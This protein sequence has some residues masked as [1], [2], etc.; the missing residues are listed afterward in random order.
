MTSELRLRLAALQGDAGIGL[1]PRLP[2]PDGLPHRPDRLYGSGLGEIGFAPDPERGLFVR[3]EAV[4]LSDLGLEPHGLALERLSAISEVVPVGSP[5]GMVLCDLETTGLQRGAGTVPFL[6]GWATVVGQRLEL[7]QWLLPQLG[8]EL[9]LVEAALDRL[10]AASLLVTYNGASYDLPLLRART[11]MTGVDR[12]WPAPPHLDLLPLV[13][14]LFR[15]RLPRCTLRSAEVGLLHRTRQGD[16]PGREAPER[17]WHFLRTGEAAPL[18]AV[19][20]HNR[21]DVVSL[22]RLL[23][24]LARHLDLEAPHPSDWLSLGRLA[25]S[26]GRLGEAAESYRRAERLSPPPLDRAGALRRARLLRRQGEADQ[27]RE[28]WTAIWQRWGDPEAAEALCVE[29]EHRQGDPRAALELARR[30]LPDA[31]VGWDQRFARRIWRLEARLG[32]PGPQASAAPD[33]GGARPWA[34]WLPGGPSYEAWLALRR[35]S[36]VGRERRLSSVG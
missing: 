30:A 13:R 15:H 8:S 20:Q 32:T 12:A 34:A 23:D 24:R 31:P 7:E 25:E 9:P 22:V 2:D 35:R 17:Y 3:S 19:V 18:E 28:A 6:Y 27:A 33:P 14:R 11:V 21:E 29:L 4:D 26:R 5:G 10:R 36:G 16:L 1:G